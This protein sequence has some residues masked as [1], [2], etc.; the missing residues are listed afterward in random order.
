[1]LASNLKLRL[2]FGLL[3]STFL[4]PAPGR[5]AAAPDFIKVN[6]DSALLVTLSQ[7]PGAFISLNE[8]INLALKNSTSVLEASAVLK[9]TKGAL[10]REKGVF[11]PELFVEAEI[12]RIHQPSAFAIP[13]VG[14]FAF[15]QEDEQLIGSAGLRLK[16]P[17]GTQVE[18]SL[19]TTRLESNSP[20]QALV[21]QYSNF[22]KIE[23]TQPLLAGFGP[24]AKAE[25]SSARRIYE[26]A[27][28]GYQAS[29]LSLSALVEQTYWDLYV[30]ERDL[31]VQILI[32]DQ[33]AAFLQET[34]LRAVAGQVG[35]NQ[36][37][38]ATVFLAEQEQSVLDR[39]ESLTKISNQL[40][41]LLG[42]R[43]PGSLCYRP[44]DQPPS[45]FPV[46][47][48]DSLLERALR[49][50]RNLKAF[51]QN[52][53]AVKALASGASWNALPQLDLFGSLGANGLSGTDTLAG[54]FNG[55]ANR[56]WTQVFQ[57]NYPSWNVG[58]R[59]TFPLGLR[60]GLGERERLQGEVDRAYQQYLAVRR[61]VEEQVRA[62]YQELV[63]AKKRLEAAQSGVGASAEQVRIG[64]LEYQVGRTTAFE[65]VR[66]TA[67]L[68]SA[69]QRYS[70]ALVRA[71]KAASE[72][73]KLT[74]DSF[75]YNQ[76]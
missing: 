31:A 12:S 52:W 37:A 18:A 33:A 65:L 21:P 40:A 60:P 49:N 47:N 28:A 14:S 48:L 11:D 27:L 61:A 55:N 20:Y 19:N 59:L 1:M 57:R 63:N 75:N 30:A 74:S 38:N 41:T 64:M 71:A 69:Q 58:V 23:I 51:E 6:P 10:R 25:V 7:F 67:D 9:S 62:T 32:R 29:L 16:S 13:Q 76:L 45:D 4:L 53:V 42:Q 72:L 70:Q 5:G 66:L 39:D 17:L 44:S 34:Q 15:V 22:G 68:A 50:N 46:E 24:A 73:K 56:A 54:P 2:F 36:A 35:P 3:L 8:A 26:A 43:P